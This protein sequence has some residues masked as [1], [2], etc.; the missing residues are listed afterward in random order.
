MSNQ[1][2]YLTLIDPSH[3]I[4]TYGYTKNKDL[5]AHSLIVQDYPNAR[6]P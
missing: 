1:L 5:Y 2:P 6:W 3:E 4:H